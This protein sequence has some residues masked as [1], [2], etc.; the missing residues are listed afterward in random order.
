MARTVLTEQ[1]AYELPDGPGLWLS[2][3]EAK[4][5]TGWEAK[6]EGMCRGNVCVRLPETARDGGAVDVAAF[7]RRLGA[8]VLSEGSAWMLG[9]AAA[10]RSAALASLE[11][12]DFTLPDLSGRAHR[13]SALRGKKVLLATWASW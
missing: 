11:A 7:W 12:P 6:P 1:A 8:P 10:E 3:A 13:L 9:A 4:R 5:V 2:E